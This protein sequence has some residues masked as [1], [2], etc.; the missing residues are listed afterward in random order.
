LHLI[1]KAPEDDIQREETIAA[2][3]HGQF[4]IQQSLGNVGTKDVGKQAERT[5]LREASCPKLPEHEVDPQSRWEKPSASDSL[6]QK[7][8]E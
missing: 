5:A 7:P 6:P 1:Q 2:V 8:S 4:S 3:F